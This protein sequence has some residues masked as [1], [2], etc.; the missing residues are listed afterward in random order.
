[1]KIN[2]TFGRVAT[3]FLA[4]AM[5]A[6]VTAV[7]AFAAGEGQGTST[8]SGLQGATFEIAKNLKV[9]EKLYTPDVDFAF[10]IEP[11]APTVTGDVT[12]QRNGVTVEEGQEG[13]IT[14]IHDASFSAGA[15]AMTA[16][17]VVP[18]D[19]NAQ[20]TVNLTAFATRGPGVYKYKVTEDSTTDPYDGVTYDN[21]TKYLYVTI[22]QGNSGLE[23]EATE[24]VN[25]DGTKTNDFNN[26]YDADTET[27][28][29]ITIYK[30]VEGGFGDKFN[31]SFTFTVTVNG[32]PNE[33]YYVETV[34]GGQNTTV[35]T[36]ALETGKSEAFTVRN[37]GYVKIYGLDADDTYTVVESN[38]EDKGYTAYV[39]TA[40]ESTH[41][42]ESEGVTKGDTIS[43]ATISTDDEVAIFNVKTSSPATGLAMD[44]APYALLVVVA[45]AGCF[46]FLRKRNDD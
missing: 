17:T 18:A 41:T 2:K 20:Y 43:A 11:E 44:I 24:L 1:M 37:D 13:D 23:V 35:T 27:L 42:H 31:D 39:D 19:Q 7:P 10:V 45:A 40:Y 14:K 9:G 8:P 22:V 26:D 28:H 36:A 6:S 12:E 25:E 38:Y 4:T 3:T 34:E 21:S 29:D 32:D 30:K 16:D 33:T 15:A 5:L 46:V